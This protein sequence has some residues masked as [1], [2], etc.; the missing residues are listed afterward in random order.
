M[1][2]TVANEKIMTFRGL[3]HGNKLST[4]NLTLE[5]ESAKEIY[6]ALAMFLER[7]TTQASIDQKL[8]PEYDFEG[9]IT[10]STE[11]LTELGEQI[12]LME[13]MTRTTSNTDIQAAITRA[14][15]LTEM[16][17]KKGI[18]AKDENVTI[19]SDDKGALAFVF[20]KKESVLTYE[21]A[22]PPIDLAEGRT[23]NKDSSGNST[24]IQRSYFTYL[25][26]LLFPKSGTILG[27]TIRLLAFIVF[28]VVSIPLSLYAHHKKST[29]IVL[30]TAAKG[31]PEKDAREAAKHGTSER[32]VNPLRHSQKSS[33]IPA[34]PAGLNGLPTSDTAHTAQL[35]MPPKHLNS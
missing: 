30:G 14:A 13:Q 25:G 31:L 17:R 18:F 15:A 3:C 5:L 19:S 7:R 23:S 6:D 35:H 11:V 1:K 12:E 29:D 28:A 2:T 33:P 10:Q 27:H 26:N 32:P 4:S 20:S 8:M 34:K 24:P 16:V 9:A 22:N 21:S